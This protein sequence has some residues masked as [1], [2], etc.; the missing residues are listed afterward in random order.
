MRKPPPTR[1][2]PRAEL[3]WE[4]EKRLEDFLEMEELRIARIFSDYLKQWNAEDARWD[5]KT[6]IFEVCVNLALRRSKDIKV[7]IAGD[8]CAEKRSCSG[9]EKPGPIGRSLVLQC[10]TPSEGAPTD[11][12]L[13]SRRL[14]ARIGR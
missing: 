12:R 4:A 10:L 9:Q 6:L 1:I 8:G 13:A 11:K 3:V 5:A 2:A 14:P 7:L